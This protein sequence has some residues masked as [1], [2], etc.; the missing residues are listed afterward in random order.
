MALFV[1]FVVL[2]DVRLGRGGRALLDAFRFLSKEV[3]PG[4]VRGPF[5]RRNCSDMGR[6]RAPL[7]ASP[8]PT[9]NLRIILA[10]AAGK[11]CQVLPSGDQRGLDSPRVPRVSWTGAPPET[12]TRQMWPMRLFSFQSGAS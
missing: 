7:A 1:V 10:L 11:K 12:G 5:D 8:R 2:K 4:V 9:S 3:D 6:K